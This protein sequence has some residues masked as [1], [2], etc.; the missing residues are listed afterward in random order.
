MPLIHFILS[1]VYE[2]PTGSQALG[3]ERR[4]HQLL[5]SPWSPP[6]GIFLPSSE[7]GRVGCAV[8][9]LYAAGLCCLPECSL[10]WGSLGASK[11]AEVLLPP[12]TVG[13]LSTGACRQVIMASSVSTTVVILKLT[14][15]THL[16]PCLALASHPFSLKLTLP[17]LFLWKT[18]FYTRL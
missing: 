11:G 2:A 4:R 14:I 18:E 12:A 13:G 15:P 10:H 6:D 9:L 17:L 5:L 16:H 7:P 3:L 8:C 1:N